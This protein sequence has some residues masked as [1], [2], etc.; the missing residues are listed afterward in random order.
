MGPPL[1]LIHWLMGAEV[2]G[3]GWMSID[4][5]HL[6]GNMTTTFSTGF[7]SGAGAATSRDSFGTPAGF[8]SGFF[9]YLFGSND[10]HRR[11]EWWG[12]GAD[13]SL[14]TSRDHSGRAPFSIEI[15]KERKQKVTHSK[16]QTERETVTSL[17]FSPRL[18]GHHVTAT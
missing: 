17:R 9:S 4:Q 11:Y 15:Q 2:A 16:R 7:G 18:I 5:H 1:H 12:G 14:H 3:C 13:W 10:C 6:N 8:L